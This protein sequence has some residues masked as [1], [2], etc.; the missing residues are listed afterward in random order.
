[1]R[2]AFFCNTTYPISS[3]HLNRR[4]FRF[5]QVDDAVRLP[6]IGGAKGQILEIRQR[7]DGT[8][9][10][11]IIMDDEAAEAAA[12]TTTAAPVTISFEDSLAE[13]QRA[14]SELVRLQQE[15][16]DNGEL[17]TAQKKKYSES[18]EK[19]GISAQKLANIQGEDDSLKLLMEGEKF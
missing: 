17:S 9:F 18:L 15:Y 3:L 19:L 14:A 4:N 7:P 1:M 12:T 13:I 11:R 10:S 5:E 2:S 16:K 8:I 6:Y